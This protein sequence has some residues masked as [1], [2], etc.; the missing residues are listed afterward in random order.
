MGRTILFKYVL[1]N[2]SVGFKSVE[3]SMMIT[4]IIASFVLF[5]FQQ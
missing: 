5:T 3:L 1:Q 2:C 4:L